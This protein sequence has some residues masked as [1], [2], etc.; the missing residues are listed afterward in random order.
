MEQGGFDVIIGNP[1]YVNFKKID[2]NFRSDN[3][4]CI[5]CKDLF[6]IT[7]ERAFQLIRESGRC[8][9]IIPLSGL[10]T[11]SMIDLKNFIF[12]KSL[13]SWN[14]YYS[15][16]D[17]P[18]SLFTGVRHRLLITINQVGVS[19]KKFRFSTN[20]LKWFSDERT[21]LFEKFLIYG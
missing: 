9:V 7:V 4:S 8:G 19:E 3:Y 14:S 13:I 16:S 2:Y 10:S 5:A 1:P 12:S 21:A 15:A 11:D 20:F 17:Q 18:A 6:A